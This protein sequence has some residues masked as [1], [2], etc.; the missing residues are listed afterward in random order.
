MTHG[1]Q[2]VTASTRP[3]R[4][5]PSF[6]RWFSRIAR[7]DARFEVE[8]IDLAEVGL[9]FLDEPK[10]P[11]FGQYE[12]QHTKDWS[13]TITRADAFVFVIPEYNYGYNAVIKNAID[14]LSAEWADKAVA[15]VSY[16]G[17]AGGT[18]AV[19][20]LKQVLTTLRMVPIFEAVNVP[21]AAA[22]LDAE[23][24][25]QPDEGRE[26]AAGAVLDE[27]ARV[28]NLLRPRT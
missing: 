12:H 23:G 8:D 2:I 27:L 19:Q 28:T 21:F 6:A 11:R 9:P 16:G 17:I 22:A 25:V 18:R 1:L 15:F 3:G 20:Q 14:F 24:N 10:H 7:E 26:A 5:G 13:A 4:I